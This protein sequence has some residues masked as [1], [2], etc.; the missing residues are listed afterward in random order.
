MTGCSQWGG[1]VPSSVLSLPLSQELL[2][3]LQQ[4]K[5]SLELATTDL[6]LTISEL[7]RELV[8]LRERERL[9]V[10]FPDLHRPMEAQIQ[11]R[12]PGSVQRACWGLGRV[13]EGS[14]GQDTG[15]QLPSL[16]R[17]W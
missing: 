7:E 10:A 13:T 12:G 8:E 14:C 15:Q 3:S 2:H 11:S 17:G 4:E 9:L 6:Q 5:Q 16:Q 1:W